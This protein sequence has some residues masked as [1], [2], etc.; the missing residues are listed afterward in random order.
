MSVCVLLWTIR[1]VERESNQTGEFVHNHQQ[2]VRWSWHPRPPRH[3]DGGEADQA[4][5]PD[6]SH[7]DWSWR[8]LTMSMS[9]CPSGLIV[10]ERFRRSISNA[11]LQFLGTL[12]V[13]ACNMTWI[14]WSICPTYHDY[15]SWTEI[16]INQWD[17]LWHF[18]C[19]HF[20]ICNKWKYLSLTH[21]SFFI[22]VSM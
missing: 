8:T 11:E 19:R 20:W 2:K 7:Q 1:G 3:K 4:E 15:K 17:A 22:N 13:P 14:R 21:P 16:A 9:G 18:L 6:T 12:S 5:K 10:C